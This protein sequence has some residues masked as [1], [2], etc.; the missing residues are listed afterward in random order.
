MRI[1]IRHD[2]NNLRSI[3]IGQALALGARAM[4]WN[5]IETDREH[6]EPKGDLIA[7]YGWANANL[8]ET[9]RRAGGSY[10][11]VDLG[12]W[13]RKKFRSDYGGMHKVVVN[14]RHATEYFQRRPRPADRMAGAPI[15]KPWRE[16]NGNRII[17]AGLSAKAAK[18]HGLASMEWEMSAI[19]MLRQITSRPLIYRPKPSWKEAAPIAGIEYSPCTVPIEDALR[20]AYALVTLHSN[21]AIDAIA[22]G[23]P[24]FASSGLP[25]AVS[26]KLI[27][28]IEDPPTV[29]AAA[30][31]QFLADVSYCHWSRDEMA[32]GAVWQHLKDEGLI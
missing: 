5:P 1:C 32:S 3:K 12:Y 29:S 15:L 20:S 23:V 25:S 9:Y 28:E 14:A 6:S 8:F 13:G 21:A 24:V 11:Y 2:P 31:Y 27:S 19:A 16:N 30:R 7:A 17:V 26:F 22:A 4:G 10:V 18:S